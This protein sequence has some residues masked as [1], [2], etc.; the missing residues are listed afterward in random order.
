MNI[1]VLGSSGAM[2][3]YFARYFLKKGH[4][5][6]GADLTRGRDFPAGLRFARSNSGA[7]RKADVVVIAVPIDETV[8]VVGEVVGSLPSGCV[9]IEIASV[10]S[11]ILPILRNIVAGKRLTLVS[12]HPLFGPSL[13]SG[14]MKMCFVGSQRD[15]AIVLKIFPEAKLIPL[16]LESHDRLMAYALSLVHLANIAFASAVER[17]LGLSEFER[18]ATPTGTL[19]LDIAKSI[20]SQDP[21]LYSYLDVENDFVPEA[22][23]SL[24]SELEQLNRIVRRGKRRE[25]E[26][27]FLTLGRTIGEKEMA[28]ALRSVYNAASPG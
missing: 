26:R 24:A 27:R 28:R 21:A 17:D 16:S 15:G 12:L 7:V 1:A 5:V 20:L 10:K 23:S 19:Q 14:P 9:L 8:R 18:V 2:G 22:L 4:N 25:F 13:R 6:S 3:S 11:R